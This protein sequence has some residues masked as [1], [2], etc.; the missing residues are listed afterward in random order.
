[1]QRREGEH[2]Q[3]IREWR[4]VE[5][6]WEASEVSLFLYS[7]GRFLNTR[8]PHNTSDYTKQLQKVRLESTAKF[9]LNAQRGTYNK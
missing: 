5:A 8:H 2:G 7:W 6:S 9:R 1:M 3:L 4:D